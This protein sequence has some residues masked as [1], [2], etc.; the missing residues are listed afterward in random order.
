MPAALIVG[1]VTVAARDAPFLLG[2]AGY[3]CF[4][5]TPGAARPRPREQPPAARRATA[6]PAATTPPS[7]ARRASTEPPES[8]VR[9]DDDDIELHNIDTIDLTGLYNEEPGRRAGRAS[10]AAS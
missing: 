8:V 7:D 10:A 4:L 5:R 9:I 6:A 1:G 3:L 2:L